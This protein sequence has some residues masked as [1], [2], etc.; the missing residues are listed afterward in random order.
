MF[1][2]S[3]VAL[4]T[5][6]KKGKVDEKGLSRLIDFHVRSGTQGI[7]PCGTTGES[8]T[9][10]Y[11]EHQRVIEIA[12]SAAGGRVPV[13]A[14]TG[15][16]STDEAILLT[17]R[18]KDAGAD[19]ALLISPY[20]N[21][22]TQEGLYQ[23]YKAVAKAVDLPLLLYNIPSRT[24]VNLLPATVARLA[25]IDGIVGIKE[26]TGSLQQVSDLVQCCPKKFAIISGDDFTALPTVAVGGVGVISVTANIVPSEMAQMM[27]AA[28]KGDYVTAGRLH[29]QVYALH[30]AMFME[31][32]PGPVKAALALMG[33]CSAKVRLPLCGLSAENATVLSKILS[34]YG[35][36]PKA[37]AGTARGGKVRRKA[38]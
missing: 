11:E 30:G 38:V 21:K 3:I 12:V 35:L 31:T 25:A 32:N 18:A 16:N 13:I 4:V 24:G 8:A 20:Y 28:A 14:G 10:T 15:S 23:H 5:P 26:G 29:Y 6:F 33:K 9:L 1:S 19:G 17:R 7:V 37:A 2:G 27:A 36:T 22:P 34:D